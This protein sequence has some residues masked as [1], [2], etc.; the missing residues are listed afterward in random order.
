MPGIRVLRRRDGYRVVRSALEAGADRFGMRVVQFS[1]QANHLH[2]ICEAADRRALSRGLQGLFVRIARGLNRTLGRQG[3]VFGDRYHEHVLVTPR[4]VRAAL[5]YVLHN[6]RRHA[7]RRGFRRSPWRLDPCSSA[8]QFH[9]LVDRGPD[10]E[11]LA[12]VRLPA[13]RSWLLTT[14]WRR[15][16]PI[17]IDG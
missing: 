1:V 4:E 3:Q 14:G 17:H 6:D 15:A 7:E 5:A 16:G 12:D 2:L 10:G 9:G 11:L 13:A 8:R